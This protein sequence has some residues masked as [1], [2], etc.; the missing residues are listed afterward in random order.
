MSNIDEDSRPTH[1][2][3]VTTA[4]GGATYRLVLSPR[5]M[6]AITVA[7]VTNEDMASDCH[8]CHTRGETRA[9]LMEKCGQGNDHASD[10]GCEECNDGGD[11]DDFT[12]PRRA[13][14]P[15]EYEGGWSDYADAVALATRV[16]SGR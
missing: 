6:R 13:V 8:R 15:P 4:H 14:L 11:P 5:A 7:K 10:C 1:P 2:R 12:E 3:T 16:E 9:E